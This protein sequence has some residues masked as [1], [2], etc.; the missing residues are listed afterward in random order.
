M[1][2]ETLEVQERTQA[3]LTPAAIEALEKCELV[4]VVYGWCEEA[5]ADQTEQCAYEIAEKVGAMLEARDLV[6]ERQKAELNEARRVMVD[7]LRYFGTITKDA[8]MAVEKLKANVSAAKNVAGQ[9]EA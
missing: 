9:V 3:E 5:G 8:A 2:D 1:D 6:I 7:T 4:E